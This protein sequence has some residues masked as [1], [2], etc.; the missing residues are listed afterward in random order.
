MNS[1]YD[2]HRGERL[3]EIRCIN[4][5]TQVDMAKELNIP[6][7]E[8]RCIERSEEQPSLDILLHFI[9]RFNV[10]PFYLGL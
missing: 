9:R 7:K 1:E 5:I 3:K 10:S 6:V 2:R 8:L 4:H